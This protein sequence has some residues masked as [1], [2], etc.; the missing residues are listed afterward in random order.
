MQFAENA[1]K[2][3][4]GSLMNACR[5]TGSFGNAQS[6]VV[7]DFGAFQ[8]LPPPV[9]GSQRY[10]GIWTPEACAISQAILP[11][12][13]DERWPF[14]LPIRTQACNDS[15]NDCDEH[16]QNIPRE[17]GKDFDYAE[18]AKTLDVDAL[19]WGHR[20]GDDD[21]EGAHRANSASRLRPSNDSRK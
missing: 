16:T 5:R 6:T 1:R 2:G 12:P 8:G 10:C 15:G 7:K 13:R 4:A 19:K 20:R 18:A 17:M 3:P 21:L 9:L 14:I 11:L